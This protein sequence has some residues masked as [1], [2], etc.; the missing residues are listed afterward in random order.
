MWFCRLN[1]GE[2]FSCSQVVRIILSPRFFPVSEEY[3]TAHYLPCWYAVV[4][5]YTPETVFLDTDVGL[6]GEL[7][8]LGWEWFFVKDHVKSL[9]AR[10]RARRWSRMIGLIFQICV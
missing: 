8:R 2:R 9:S 5:E 1:T 7:R 6:A 3:V 10:N 4:K